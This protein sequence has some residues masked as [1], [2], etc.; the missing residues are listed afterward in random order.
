[1]LLSRYLRIA[2]MLLAMCRIKD[3]Q[4]VHKEFFVPALCE[5]CD[6][7]KGMMLHMYLMA[8]MTPVTARTVGLC[9]ILLSS[10]FMRACT[11]HLGKMAPFKLRPIPAFPP[12]KMSLSFSLGTSQHYV[13]P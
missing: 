6:N 4:A 11:C 13:R 1:M 5:G 8:Q 12:S 7:N 10:W 3:L 9:S 2:C